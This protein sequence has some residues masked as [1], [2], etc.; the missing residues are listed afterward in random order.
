MNAQYI[1]RGEAMQSL[2]QAEIIFS[3]GGTIEN[4]YVFTSNQMPVDGVGK[5]TFT[6]EKNGMAQFSCTVNGM[7]NQNTC[8]NLVDSTIVFAGDKLAI[9]TTHDGTPVSTTATVGIYLTTQYP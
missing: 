4:L 7:V 9:K 2:Q 8:N 6:I 3:I 1:G 5:W